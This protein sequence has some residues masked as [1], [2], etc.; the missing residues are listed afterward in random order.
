MTS[1]ADIYNYTAFGFALEDGVFERFLG[2]A[3]KLGAAAPPFELPD[4]EGR[5]HRLDDWQGKPVVIEFGSYT[6]PIF[7]GHNP[8]MERLAA[9]HPE[10][11]F[12]VIYTREAHPGERVAAHASVADKARV[13]RR[14]VEEEPIG[15]LVLVDDL[16][17]T[18]HRAFG[19]VWDPVFVLDADQTVVLRRA[20]NDPSHVATALHTLRAG[21][22]TRSESI[23]MSPPTN[24][25][26][27]GH[28]LL[29]GGRQ[30]L[31]DFY[32]SAPAAVRERLETSQSALV[33]EVL[34]RS[35]ARR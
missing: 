18:V 10:V 5:H 14:L 24:V 33:R 6:C 26:G 25:A 23:E 3:P 12:V 30:A 9:E 17:G 13:A 29:R 15:R 20:W 34:D 32:Y 28:G 31:L 2:D 11:V 27:F 7:C 22:R 8:A 35:R 19:A 21:E 4:L 1:P 16:D